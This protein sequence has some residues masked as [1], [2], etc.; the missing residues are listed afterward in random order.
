MKTK[1]HFFSLYIKEKVLNTYIKFTKKIYKTIYI[2]Q[3]YVHEHTLQKFITTT[4]IL[5]IE[6]MLKTTKIMLL[7]ITKLDYETV[8]MLYTHCDIK[9][10]S[11]SL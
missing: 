11:F 3:K 2:G 1:K 5:Y 8:S 7:F 10:R 4:K 9:L 6:K